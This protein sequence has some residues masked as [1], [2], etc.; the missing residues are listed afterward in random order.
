MN[1]FFFNQIFTKEA[2]LEEIGSFT[3][4][5]ALNR[6]D[7]A[8]CFQAFWNIYEKDPHSNPRPEKKTYFHNLH[9]CFGKSG[10]MGVF[11][12]SVKLLLK[13]F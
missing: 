8:K 13:S 9:L 7:C 5:N 3:F 11:I 12:I 10:H 6:L 1:A 4:S 2:Y